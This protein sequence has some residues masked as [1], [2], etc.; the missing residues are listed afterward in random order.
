MTLIVDK[1]RSIGDASLETGIPE[2]VIRF[3][4]TQFSEYIKPIIGTGKRRYFYNDDIKVLNTIREYLYEKG[5]TIKGLK[6]LIEQETI[7]AIETK[8]EQDIKNNIDNKQI[9]FTYIEK[10]DKNLINDLRLF[11]NKL[12]NFYDKLKNI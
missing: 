10:T 5:Y 12:N 11:K 4:Q 9:K 8:K 2:Y 6:K 1:K 3:W 7:F